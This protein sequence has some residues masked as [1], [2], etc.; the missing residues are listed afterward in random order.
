MTIAHPEC[1]FVAVGIQHAMLMRHIVICDLP[2]STVF[3]PHYLVNVTFFG[4]KVSEHKMCVLI[5]STIFV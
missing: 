1:V 5:F 3:Y 4:K 2:R